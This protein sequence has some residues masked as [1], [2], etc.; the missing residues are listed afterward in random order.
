MNDAEREAQIRQDM[1]SANRNN[2]DWFVE[3]RFFRT[4][5]DEARAEIARL[6]APPGADIAAIIA[7]FEEGQE[8][9]HLAQKLERYWLT[10]IKPALLSWGG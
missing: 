5:L 2:R 4:Q 10:A 9:H 3:A 1:D 8:A 7:D 6:T